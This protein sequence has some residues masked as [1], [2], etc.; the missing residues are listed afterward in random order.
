MIQRFK[1]KEEDYRGEFA[2]DASVPQKG[3][4]DLL[5]VTQP[6][7]IRS[8]HRQYLEAGADII[9]TCS[10]NSQQISLSDYEMQGHVALFNK[11]AAKLA[12][13]MA[14][15]YTRKDPSKPRSVAGSV[16]PTN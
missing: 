8:I 7:V 3:N 11:S 13:E 9:E 6:D 4:N 16:G 15:E 5:C 2:K 14:D 10:F 1:L 12:R